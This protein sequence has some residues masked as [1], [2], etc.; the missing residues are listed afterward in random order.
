MPLTTQELTKLEDILNY[1]ILDAPDGAD[2]SN[3]AL[4]LGRVIEVR[5]EQESAQEVEQGHLMAAL[6]KMD[7][8]QEDLL[9]PREWDD[10]QDCS[11]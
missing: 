7:D 4:L 2:V 9:G 1:A 3:E 8:D 10:P 5:R 6:A 11:D